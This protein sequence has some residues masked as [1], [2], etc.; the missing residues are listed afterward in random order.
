M[1]LRAQFFI[2]IL[3]CGLLGGC[4]TPTPQS[5]DFSFA[6]LA[7]TQYNEREE[8]AFANMLAALNKEQFAF[9]VH[10]GDFKAGSNA[11]CTDAIFTR[12]L[13]E[14]Q[15]SENPFI[16]IPGD[17]DWVDC[18][19]AS[20]GSQDPLERL[21]K[22]R[23]L[24]YRDDQSIGKRRIPV[25]RQGAPTA[26]DSTVR[27]VSMHYPENMRWQKNGIVF[28][29]VNVQGSNDN[30]GFTATS[31]AEQR[32]RETSNI[33][34]MHTAFEI[35]QRENAVGVVMFLQAN[36][37]FE[38]PLAKVARSA[39]LPFLRAFEATATAWNKPVMFAHGD[40]HQFRLLPYESPI[41]RKRIGNVTRLETFG[42]P[43]TN[44][45][46]VNV[47]PNNTQAPFEVVLG[48]M[49]Y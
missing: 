49:G 44:W 17:N 10:G 25:E 39:Y 5:R 15:Q 27:S 7:D 42:S 1:Q 46:R 2:L 48:G 33:A 19:R 8:R 43:H 24:F 28:F 9:V 16:F 21:A 26:L 32:Q 6:F 11:P 45:V 12:R 34:W 18:Q 29:T 30:V 36:P 35:A 40:T 38:E 22:L 37:G 13:A 31:D 3:L 20:N 47:R 41:D 14:Y 23:E 4:A